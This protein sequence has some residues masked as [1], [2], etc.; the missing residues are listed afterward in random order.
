MGF[1]ASMAW[2]FLLRVPSELLRQFKPDLLQSLRGDGGSVRA[3]LTYGPIR[4]KACDRPVVL[5]RPCL[6]AGSSKL[7]CPHPWL[8]ALAWHG[9]H[10][11]LP[12]GSMV[13]HRLQQGVAE[14]GEPEAK[15][16]ASHDWRRGSAFDVLKS[17]G[18]HAMMV[19]G[20]WSGR[21]AFHYVPRDA[22]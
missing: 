4:R 3:W 13:N 20:G 11:S 15:H 22:V 12:S 6:C 5:Q 10:F 16:Y 18:L 17:E 19:L 2:L 9:N 1:I 8:R 7:L 14:L 21:A